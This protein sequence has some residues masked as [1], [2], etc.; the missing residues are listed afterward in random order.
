VDL[1]P[2]YGWAIVSDPTGNTGFLLS[3]TR[4]VSDE[5]YQELLNRASVRGV[6][7]WITV[8]PQPA[9]ARELSSTIRV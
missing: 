1:A 6:K 8:T 5:L 3:R 4:T 9:A 7:G 2:D